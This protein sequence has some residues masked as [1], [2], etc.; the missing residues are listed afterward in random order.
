[1]F[2]RIANSFALARSSWNVLRT[3]KQLIVFP[4]LSGFCCLL[5][6]LSFAAP[7]ITLLVVQQK[8]P[9]DIP[10]WVYYITA[11]A[12]YFATYFIIIFC[13]SALTSCAL[14]RFNG[15]TPTVGAGLQAAAVRLPQILAWALVSAR[16][17][18]W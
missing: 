16:L 8:Q 18:E 6:L 1:M 10:Q 7:F 12:F 2:D 9:E 4:I 5:V 14:M 11:F 17:R 15:E 13:N 3:D